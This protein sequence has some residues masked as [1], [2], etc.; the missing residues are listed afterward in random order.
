MEGLQIIAIVFFG[1]FGL[2]IIVANWVI[3]LTS[4]VKK[5]HHSFAP[6]LGLGALVV[7]LL[8]SPIW[9]LWWIALIIDVGTVPLLLWSVGAWLLRKIR[10]FSD[11]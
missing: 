1:G 8:L 10:K 5:E 4:L 6:F 9:Q 2:Y 3:L 7:A 11:E